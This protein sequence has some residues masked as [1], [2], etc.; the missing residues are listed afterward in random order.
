MIATGK[1]F[2]FVHEILISQSKKEMENFIQAKLSIIIWKEHL[3][4][5]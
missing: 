4:K 5:L 2:S 1:F 3:R